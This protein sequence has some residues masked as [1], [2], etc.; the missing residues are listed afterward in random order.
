[1]EKK[2]Y[3]NKNERMTKKRDDEIS[4][5][6]RFSEN[7]VQSVISANFCSYNKHFG[8][9]RNRNKYY[10]AIEKQDAQ[11]PPEHFPP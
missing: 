9:L 6:S 3:N 11:L 2:T 10:N 5:G 1:M 8:S 4:D 7:L